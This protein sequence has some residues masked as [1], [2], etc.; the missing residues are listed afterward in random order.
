LHYRTQPRTLENQINLFRTNPYT[1]QMGR[2][3]LEQL[4]RRIQEF[5]DSPASGDLDRFWGIL[6]AA[7]FNVQHHTTL[8]NATPGLS[9]HGR[10]TAIDF[11]VMHGHQK[12]ADTLTSQIPTVWKGASHWANKLAAA[13]HTLNAQWGYPVFDGP[14]DFPDEPWHYNYQ[15]SPP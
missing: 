9:T 3:V 13:V 4:E 14:L 10:M 1:D 6:R 15:G 2:A 5:P 11:I 8:T 7:S 12:V